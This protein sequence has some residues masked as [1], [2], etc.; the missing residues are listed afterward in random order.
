SPR[1][2][3]VTRLDI[4]VISSS[5]VLGARA[6]F[7]PCGVLLVA[8]AVLGHLESAQAWAC[9]GLPASAR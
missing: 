4:C 3:M 9:N 2:G 1:A 5:M 6:A 8:L 7:G